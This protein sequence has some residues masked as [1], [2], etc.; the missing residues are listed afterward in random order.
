MSA[1][2]LQ[3]TSVRLGDHRLHLQLEGTRD[4]AP[5]KSFERRRGSP[6][7]PQ[8]P[9]FSLSSRSDRATDP[10]ERAR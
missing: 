1:L 2:L 9:V 8:R 4:T 5:A 7:L 6:A 10:R 3:D